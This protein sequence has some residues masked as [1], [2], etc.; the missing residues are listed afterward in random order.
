MKAVGTW[1]GSY[2]TTLEDDRG[3][4]VTV[5]LPRDEDGGDLGTSALELN[6][7]SLAGC[8]TTIFALVAKRR[9]LSFEQMRVELEANRPEGSPTVESVEGTFRIVTSAPHADVET[10]LR[11]TLRTCPVGVIYGRAGIPVHVRPIV[12]APERV[13]AAAPA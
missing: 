1:K 8:I 3:H 5:D 7:L 4:S 11:L 2:R 9:R 12:V 13:A 10:A 6:V